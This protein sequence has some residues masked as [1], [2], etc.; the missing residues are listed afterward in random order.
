MGRWSNG[1]TLLSHGRDQ[2]SIPWRSTDWKVAGYGW[3]GRSGTSVPREGDEGSTPLPSAWTPVVKRTSCLPSKEAFRV[4]LLVGV[5]HSPVVQRQDVPVTWGR[6]V[7]RFHPG[8]LAFRKGYPI[9]DGN[10][11]LTAS[12]ASLAGSTPAPS[13]GPPGAVDGDRGV[14]AARQAVDLEARVQC[15]SITLTQCRRG[16]TARHRPRKPDHT[17]ASPVVGSDTPVAHRTERGSAKPE[18][19]G[20]I[21]ARSAA[22]PH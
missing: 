8:L 12:S 13:A 1:Q 19:A 11:L 16:R 15:P 22:T 18:E 9:G 6:A 17:G 7:V 5:L 4:R 2:G 20:S 21:P 10:R 3:P 14:V